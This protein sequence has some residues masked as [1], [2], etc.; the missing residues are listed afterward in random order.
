[1]KLRRESYWKMLPKSVCDPGEVV[2]INFHRQ[3][4]YHRPLS[5]GTYQEP[6]EMERVKN[7]NRPI[8]AREHGIQPESKGSKRVQSTTL[9][10]PGLICPLI[11]TQK[12]SIRND[13]QHARRPALGPTTAAT[14]HVPPVRLITF[15]LLSDPRSYRY[16]HW[17]K[18]AAI[19]S[20]EQKKRN[21]MW[22][23]RRAVVSGK[24]G[25][26]RVA[27]RNL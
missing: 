10:R 16:S 21:Y 4:C 18:S 7:N 2:I 25:G 9:D 8:Q 14:M 19:Q 6:S 26:A 11:D 20:D 24:R 23:R 17:P 12:E 15:A 3:R 13:T 27:Y 22:N 1:M 5:Q